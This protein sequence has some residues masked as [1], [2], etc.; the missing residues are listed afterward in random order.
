MTLSAMKSI[1]IKKFTWNQIN[2][3]DVIWP[4]P[5]ETDER[6]PKPKQQ[7]KL[8]LKYPMR[9]MNYPKPH[10]KNRRHRRELYSALELA[11]EK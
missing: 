1:P 2:E 4:I 11:L 5:S 10:W 8:N 7:P 6:K 3:L 9:K